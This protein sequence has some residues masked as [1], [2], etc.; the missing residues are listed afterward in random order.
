MYY[1]C[2][3][4]SWGTK[5]HLHAKLNVVRFG[6]MRLSVGS[7][8]MSMWHRLKEQ[9]AKFIPD[10]IGPFLEMTLIKQPDLRRT[11]LPVVFDIM[12]CVV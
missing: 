8:V 1:Y 10:L 7:H 11:T 5:V 3:Y 12:R 4:S 6:D 2:T 9:K